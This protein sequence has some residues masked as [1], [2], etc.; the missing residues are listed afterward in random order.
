MNKT[1]RCL[2]K[3]RGCFSEA[4]ESKMLNCVTASVRTMGSLKLDA[5]Q[6]GIY[7]KNSPGFKA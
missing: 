1:W 2:L 5:W 4:D 6:L 7:A 3:M